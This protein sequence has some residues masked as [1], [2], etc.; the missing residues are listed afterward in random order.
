MPATSAT[1]SANSPNSSIGDDT[2][3]PF[4]SLT[5][6]V[7]REMKAECYSPGTYH[8]V[9]NPGSFE[10]LPEY[11]SDTSK[12]RKKNGITKSKRAKKS[13]RRDS[14]NSCSGSD[15]PNIIILRKFEEPS[16]FALFE[17]LKTPPR[18][19]SAR[20]AAKSK[21]PSACGDS[22]SVFSAPE[23]ATTTMRHTSL[24]S[25]AVQCGVDAKLIVH[26]REVVWQH[27]LETASYCNLEPQEGQRIPG[28]EIF[29]R[30]AVRF[31]P[32]NCCHM[33]VD[34]LPYHRN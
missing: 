20:N 25:I 4:T 26:F 27:L 22:V 7:E 19:S 16:N 3:P 9:V 31:R 2:L 12:M 8:V 21:S 17:N 23:T 13:R 5:S 11:T 29:E 32:V 30:E 34:Y 6:D 33:S 14:I 1:P 18:P 15:D 28:P 10:C 24:E